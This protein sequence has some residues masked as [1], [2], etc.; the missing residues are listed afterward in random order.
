M[1]LRRSPLQQYVAKIRREFDWV[2]I[3]QTTISFSMLIVF[4]IAP[5]ASLL[6][7][8]FIFRGAFSLNWFADILG[9]PE[10][11]SFSSRGGR[12]FQV[13]RGTMYIWGNDHCT[14]IHS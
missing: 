3:L 5:L 11:V 2:T 7:R 6:G 4:L 9:S 8:A 10:F 13:I 12:M 1:G 14:A